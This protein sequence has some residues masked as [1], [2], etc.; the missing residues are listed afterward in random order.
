M[1]TF[2]PARVAFVAA[3]LAPLA[4][5]AY[6]AGDWVGRFGVHH[7][8]PK[9]HNHDTI[10]VDSTQGVTGSLAW[11]LTPQLAVDLLVAVPFKHD[12]TL[13]GAGTVASTRHLPPTL[14]LAWYPQVSGA[15]HPYVGLGMNY[16]LFFDEDTQGALAGADLELDPSFGAAALVGVDWDISQ[17]WGLALDLRYMDIDT[18]ASANGTDLGTVE[19]DPLAAGISLSYRFR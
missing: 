18:D 4:A 3:L 12:I 19:I 10:G 14:S 8:E 6:E 16:T 5:S 15:W 2:F 7:I 1:N 17:N 9:S 11:F 13:Q